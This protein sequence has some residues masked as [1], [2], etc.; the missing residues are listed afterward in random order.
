MKVQVSTE[1]RNAISIVWNAY[2]HPIH[3]VNWNF[4]STDWCCP[5]ANLDLRENGKFL[6]RM[7]ARDGTMGFDFSGCFTKIVPN[8]LLE[9][10]LDDGRTVRVQFEEK[11]DWIAVC[12]DFD[13]ETVNP[14]ELQRDG[15]Q[16]ILNQFKKYIH[17]D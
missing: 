9:Y 10:V 8:K 14:I 2:T 12:I 13:P 4:A 1:I 15:W 6:Y 16:A 7:Q 3:I 5:K 17:K 11:N